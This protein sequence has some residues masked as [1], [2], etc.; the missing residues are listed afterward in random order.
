MSDLLGLQN[1]GSDA[2][3]VN[4]LEF[5]IE[6]ILNRRNH[7]VLVKV[8]SAPYSADGTP[9]TPG[10]AAPIGYVDVLP[11]V[12]QVDGWG[13]PVPHDV[14]YHLSYFRYQGGNNA[15]ICD[16]AVGDIGKMVIADRD[17]SIVKAT[18]QQSNPGS[19]R[20]GSFSDGTYFGMTQGPAPTQY[21]AWLNQGFMIVD[22]YGN[23]IQG[24]PN[25]VLINGALITL[26]GDVQ[27]KQGT[28]L[29][30]H[31]HNQPKDSA[32]NTEYTTDPPNV[33]S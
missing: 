6:R 21:F 7:A 19:G 30:T 5:I 13:L 17:T 29:T 25:G 28:S 32:G 12:N 33:G 20:R 8:V 26:T 4:A 1:F 23:T 31:T 11:L 3:D 16:P 9:I 24:T 14:V 27:N 2:S 10:S 22:A 15:F 18:G